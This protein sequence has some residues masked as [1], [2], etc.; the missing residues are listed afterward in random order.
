VPSEQEQLL[1]HRLG[2][3]EQRQRLFVFAGRLSRAIELGE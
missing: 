2:G 1:D 3:G